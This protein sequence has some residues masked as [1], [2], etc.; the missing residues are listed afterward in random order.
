MA[1]Q[2]TTVDRSGRIMIPAEVRRQL[3]IGEG[4]VLSVGIQEGRIVLTSR[5]EAIRRAQAFFKSVDPDRVLSEEL[6]ED[7]RREAQAELE[8]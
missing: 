6:S 2:S 3:H 4:D 5:K 7:R 8:D 1:S